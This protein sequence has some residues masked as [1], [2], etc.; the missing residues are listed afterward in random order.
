MKRVFFICLAAIGCLG[1][2]DRPDPL[3][4]ESGL[5]ACRNDGCSVLKTCNRNP[6]SELGITCEPTATK[7]EFLCS[8]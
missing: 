2:V 5:V 1:E 8:W 4:C 6:S 3:S 7:G